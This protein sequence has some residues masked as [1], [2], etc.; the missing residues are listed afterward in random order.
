MELQNWIGQFIGKRQRRPDRAHNDFL[1]LCTS[2]NNAADQSI[3]TSLDQTAGGDVGKGVHSADS[4]LHP[5]CHQKN[6]TDLNGL[7]GRRQYITVP[8]HGSIA[9]WI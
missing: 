3:I 2:D 8:V 5:I 1:G 6:A 7:Y 9:R 4:R